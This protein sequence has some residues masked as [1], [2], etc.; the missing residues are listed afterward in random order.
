MSRKQI[1]CERNRNP[2]S[3]RSISMHKL[4]K[5]SLAAAAIATTVLSAGTAYAKPNGGGASTTSCTLGS[6]TYPEGTKIGL[7]K[8]KGGKWVL[9]VDLPKPLPLPKLF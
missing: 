7:L 5:A 4:I 3:A 2:T 1:A 8:C 9:L 6:A